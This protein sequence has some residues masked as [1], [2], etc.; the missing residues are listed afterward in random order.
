[1]MSTSTGMRVLVA[2]LVKR[3]GATRDVVLDEA[4][5][6]LRVVGSELAGEGRVHLD[7][8]LERIHE[9]LVVRG[10]IAA[11]WE[12]TCA[13]CLQ[14][15]A[16]RIEVAVDELFESEPLEGDTYLLD[17]DTIDLEPMTRDALGLELPLAPV[18]RDDCAGLCPQCGVDRNR[19]QC[20]C[21][22]DTTDHR[23]AGLADLRFDE[24][25]D[26]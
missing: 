5:G 21:A 9:G 3:Q 17:H 7:L 2:D 16:G 23:W 1:M 13:R 4:V 24:P 8:H 12:G 26:V 10:T 25:T 20:G 19:E 6:E 11:D 18:C 15:V 14:P 22:D